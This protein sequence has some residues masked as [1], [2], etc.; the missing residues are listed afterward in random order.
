VAM[1]A[2]SPLEVAKPIGPVENLTG[3]AGAAAYLGIPVAT[4][5]SMV[6]RG[7]IPF[8]RL[9]PRLVRFDLRELRE[10]CAHKRNVPAAAGGGR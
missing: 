3:Y 2:S 8:Y 9:S 10:W 4:V 6:C 7:T 1:H 5:R